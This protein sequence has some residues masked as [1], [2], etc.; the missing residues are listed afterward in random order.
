MDLIFSNR[1][2]NQQEENLKSN[3]SDCIDIFKGTYD[4]NSLKSFNL[5]FKAQFT[6]RLILKTGLDKHCILKLKF[7]FLF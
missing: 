1:I 5:L 7:V 6:E 4:T 3:N 2:F